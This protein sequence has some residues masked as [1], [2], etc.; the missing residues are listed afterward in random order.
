MKWKPSNPEPTPE[1]LSAWADGELSRP[2]AE[3]VERWLLAHPDA[4]RD[5]ESTARLINLFRDHPPPEPSERAWQA[6]FGQIESALSHPVPLS[7]RPQRPHW[8]FRLLLALTAAAAILGGLALARVFWPGP[9]PLRQAP[10]IVKK[11]ANEP[12]LA[13][14]E[15]EE[16]FPVATTNEVN[17]L[18]IDVE[19]ADRVVTV[20]EPLMGLFEVAAPQEIDVE[21]MQPHAADGQT[22]RFQR[23]P[24]V[25]MILVASAD[26]EGP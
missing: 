12:N 25:P 24:E 18:S 10:E 15:P 19:D 13:H 8:P 1:Q 4:G 22:P 26:R 5:A 9:A 23:G 21:E 16:P 11:K 14:E 2:D 3:A 17:I 7:R 20:G 6:A